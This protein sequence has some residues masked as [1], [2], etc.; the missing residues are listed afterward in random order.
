[1]HACPQCHGPLRLSE[2]ACDGCGLALR[3]R[4]TRSRLARLD[5]GEQQLVEALLLAG[6]NLK[7]LERELGVSYPT[8]RKRVGEARA[9]LERLRREDE[10]AIAAWLDQVERGELPADEA[11]R[12]IGGLHGS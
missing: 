7:A 12:M 11:A 10:R 5:P 2:L 3:A 8:V 4:F 1:M 9:S 6:G